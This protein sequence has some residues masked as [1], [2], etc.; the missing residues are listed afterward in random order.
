M[1]QIIDFLDFTQ[2]INPKS[3]SFCRIEFFVLNEI[4]AKYL[5]ELIK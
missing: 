5:F 4:F 2:K 1:K 3:D